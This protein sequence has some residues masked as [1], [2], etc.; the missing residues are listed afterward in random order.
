MVDQATFAPAQ[1]TSPDSVVAVTSAIPRNFGAMWSRDI[2]LAGR[3][4]AL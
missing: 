4:S 3:G 1:R 2:D